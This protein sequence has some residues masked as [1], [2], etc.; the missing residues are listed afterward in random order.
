[1]FSIGGAALTM[2]LI[3]GWLISI[4]V[5]YR[6]SPLLLTWCLAASAAFTAIGT[7][8]RFERVA[9]LA[10]A[11][12]LLVPVAERHRH[13]RGAVLLVGVPWMAL[14]AARSLPQIAHFTAYSNDDWLAYQAAGYRIFMHGFWLEGGSKVFDYQPLYRWISGGLHLAFG[15][16]SVGE[17]Y[18]DAICLLLGGCVGFAVVNRA[19]GF[20]WALAAFVGTLATYWLGTIWYFVGRGLSE[21]AAAGW[22]FIAALILMEEGGTTRTAALAGLFAV[23]MFYTRLNHLLFAFFL[24]ALMTPFYFRPAAAYIATFVSGVLFFAARTWWYTGHFSVLYGTSLKNNDTG[25]RLATV[26]SPEVWGKIWHSLRAL[27]WMNE[28]PSPDS[29]AALV[30]TGAVLSIAVLLR[31]PKFNRL[32]FGLAVVIAGACVSSL[33]AHTHNYPGRMSVH[34]APFAV[35]MTMTAGAKLLAR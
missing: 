15:D 26:A 27:V 34:L 4:A 2:I 21:V 12:A 25:L 13:V 11:A 23:L 3:A 29:R 31:L 32:P 35:A 22:A 6:T 5:E 20:R 16:S 10:L 1:L 14:I 8:G 17:V 24:V 7:T 19:A 33:F 30:V 18:W 28:P 9:V